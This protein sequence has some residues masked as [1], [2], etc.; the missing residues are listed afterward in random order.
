MYL[1]TSDIRRSGKAVTDKAVV[2]NLLQ[3]AHVGYLGL[4]DQGNPYVVPM[5][6]V[7]HQE[8]VYLHGA[9][10]GKK[11]A[12]IGQSAKAVFTVAKD[13]GII[14]DPVPAHVG[15]A[16][17]SVMVFGQIE[18]VVDLEEATS[19]LDVM[20]NKYVPGY[21][22]KPLFQQHVERY[23]SSSGSRVVVYRLVPERMTAKAA[24]IE[25]AHMFYPGRTLVKDA[26]RLTDPD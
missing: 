18:V 8:M 10:A 3:T 16:Y 6:F 7:W 12:L 23:V 9:E 5:N 22:E 14:A 26:S 4:A 15:T 1:D 21:Y 24:P 19:A 2:T 17:L 20:L 13:Y 11:A 25:V